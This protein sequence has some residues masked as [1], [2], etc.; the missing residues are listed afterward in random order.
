MIQFEKLLDILTALQMTGGCDDRTL[1]IVAQATG[2]GGYFKPAAAPVV[3][4][5]P[6]KKLLPNCENGVIE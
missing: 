3:V 6:K 1:V 2:L 5:L 4:E